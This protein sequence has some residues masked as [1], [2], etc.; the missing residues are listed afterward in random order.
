MAPLG[1]FVQGA[2]SFAFS[3]FEEKEKVSEP[4]QA[5]DGIYLFE[6]DAFFEKG[7]DFERAKPRIAEILAK[8]EK[9]KLAAKELESRLAEIKSAAALPAAAGKAVLDSTSAG[10]VSA[11]SWLPG[12][13]Y[14]S[15]ELYQTF[16]QPVGE[17]GPVRTTEQGAV[18][19]RVDEKTFL[20]DSEAIQKAAAAPP[21]NES[22]TL[23]NL[24]QSWM[25]ELPKS[26]KVENKLDMVFRN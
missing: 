17:W 12:Y 8:E 23:S 1:R 16:S 3:E 2:N 20:T 26:A 24:V 21:Q 13:G 6:K 22:F 14:S 7:R 25:A 9:A 18:V 19:A 10:P 15:P 11:D 4:L 5:E